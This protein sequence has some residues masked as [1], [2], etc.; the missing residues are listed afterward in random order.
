MIDLGPFETPKDLPDKLTPEYLMG[1]YVLCPHCRQIME[2]VGVGPR[3][4]GYDPADQAWKGYFIVQL[5]DGN[6]ARMWEN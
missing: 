5:S 1:K 2:V 4:E 3:E 6:H